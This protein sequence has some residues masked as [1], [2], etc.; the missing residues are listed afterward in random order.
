[1]ISIVLVRQSPV[2][3]LNFLSW[4]L[5]IINCVRVRFYKD[6]GWISGI[7]IKFSGSSLTYRDHATHIIHTLTIYWS[8]SELPVS[9]DLKAFLSNSIINSILLTPPTFHD[10]TNQLIQHFIGSIGEDFIQRLDFLRIN[11]CANQILSGQMIN[12]VIFFI[13]SS[14]NQYHAFRTQSLRVYYNCSCSESSTC[15][16]NIGL[17]NYYQDQMTLHI[18]IPHTRVGGYMNEVLRQSAL[19]FFYN[20]TCVNMLEEYLAFDN[21]FIW[22]LDL[23]QSSRY[24]PTIVFG[25]LIEHVLIEQWIW[26]DSYASYYHLCQS[27]SC[28]Q[29]LTTKQSFLMLLT[30]PIDLLRDL[31]NILHT[32]VPIRVGIVQ[33][34]PSLL[35]AR[36]SRSIHHCKDRLLH[37]LRTFNLFRTKTP[38]DNGINQIWIQ[39]ISTRKHFNLLHFH[40]IHHSMLNMV[41]KLSV[42]ALR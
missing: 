18:F 39:I 22:V 40:L 32:I 34:P 19:E 30:I 29:Q 16:T 13:E 28:S 3:M 9:N 31:I 23:S 26:N 41:I 20:Q 27:I 7:S 37:R 42:F 5:F 35:H 21:S 2:V 38:L 4:D 25:E 17:Y 11:S 10:E 6:I 36:L 24:Y 12:F 8:L 14:S 33:R 15:S 1:M